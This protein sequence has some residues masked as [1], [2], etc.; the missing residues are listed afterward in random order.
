M[1]LSIGGFRSPSELPPCPA[2]C[3]DFPASRIVAGDIFLQRLVPRAGDSVI[4]ADRIVVRGHHGDRRV[5]VSRRQRRAL[6]P[7]RLSDHRSGSAS[8]LAGVRRAALTTLTRSA[9]PP[10]HRTPRNW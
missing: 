5:L 10:A 8:E 2:W 4:A 6:P 9:S 3:V 7:R 1:P